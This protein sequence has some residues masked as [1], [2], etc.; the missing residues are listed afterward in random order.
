M[1]EMALITGASSGIGFELAK[2]FARDKTDLIL[3]SRN[4]ERLKEIARDLESKYG[5]GVLVIAKNLGNKDAA[6]E[7]YD[8]VK[9]TGLQVDYL[10]N[11]AGFGDFGLFSE[12]D[13]NRQQ[14]M[15]AVNIVALTRLCRLFIFDMMTRNQGR[16]LNV[17]ST[18]AFQ[19]GP[20]MSVYNATK[21]YV[22]LFSEAIGNELKG[23][24]ITVTVL[25]PGPTDTGFLEASRLQESKL[26]HWFRNAD[27]AEVAEYGYK[28]MMKGK[29]LAIHGVLNRFM[30]F[31]VR[32]APRKLVTAIVRKMS[33][34]R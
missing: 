10:V 16:I 30:V 27:P 8:A 24:G 7:I 20:L 21:S 6:E 23:S 3:V 14:E 32:I 15:I 18:A 22:L 29:S 5:I 1:N 28:S 11:N 17:A 19:P 25:C 12:S 26:F 13:W 34:K 33:E 31:I 9:Q 4:V 2:I